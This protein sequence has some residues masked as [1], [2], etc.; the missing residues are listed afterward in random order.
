MQ[1]PE[2]T[3][4]LGN[5]QD[6]TTFGA[7]KR[8]KQFA[9]KK[10]IEWLISNNYMPADGSVRFPNPPEASASTHTTQDT[11]TAQVP[12]LC[13]RLGFMCPRYVIEPISPCA[14]IYNGYA[15]F[16]SDPRIPDHIGHVYN[17]YGKKNAKLEIAKQV[18][19]FLKLRIAKVQSQ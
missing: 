15:D 1:I 10:V 9:A 3:H 13:A 5:T 14:S 2:C 16:G 12:V 19:A 4:L 11:I 6:P 7:K 17:I 18:I 8:A